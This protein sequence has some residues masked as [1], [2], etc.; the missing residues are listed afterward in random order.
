LEKPGRRGEIRESKGKDRKRGNPSKNRMKK[1]I[2]FAP[3]AM[4]FEEF[5]GNAL[6]M[7]QE[8]RTAGISGRTLAR[9]EWVL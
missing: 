4:R 6:N 7:T 9:A 3:T 8:E 5:H 2:G 1:K